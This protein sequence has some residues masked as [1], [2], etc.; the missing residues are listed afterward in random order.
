MQ[1]IGKIII[2]GNIRT[3]TGLHIGGS[4]SAYEVG[5][6]DLNVVKDAAGR[7]YIPGSSLKGKLRSMLGRKEGYRDADSDS[8][9]IKEI[10]GDAKSGTLTRLYVRDALLDVKQFKA[11][12]PNATDYQEFE[13]SGIKFENAINRQTGVAANKALRQLERVPE[14]SV[15][16]YEIIY[17]I[18]KD[19]EIGTKLKNHL[20]SIYLAMKMLQDDYLGG[21]GSRGY[22]KIIFENSGI[23]V[24]SIKG[25]TYSDAIP[26]ALRATIEAFAAQLQFLPQ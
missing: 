26:E 16:D 4:K 14:R 9:E 19:T 24:R 10:F 1:L 25:N 20:D 11:E 22:G 5:G 21:Q 17:N 18:Q 6:V 13:F 8:Q 23:T 12:Y 15:F 2:K 3:L 7:P